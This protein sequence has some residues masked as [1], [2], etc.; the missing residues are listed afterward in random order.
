MAN[1]L[2]PWAEIEKKLPSF[3]KPQQRQ[4]RKAYYQEFWPT[5]AEQPKAAQAYY[6]NQIQPNKGELFD[7][8]YGSMGSLQGTA[9]ALAMIPTRGFGFAVEGGLNLLRRGLPGLGGLITGRKGAAARNL[10]REQKARAA[11]GIEDRRREAA[12]AL[13]D[14]AA[15]WRQQNRDILTGMD[16]E[17]ETLAMGRVAALGR[18]DLAAREAAREA[19]S[20]IGQKLL[21]AGTELMPE[22][23]RLRPTGGRAFLEPGDL[24]FPTTGGRV[25][26]QGP[27]RVPPSIMPPRGPRSVLW[28]VEV[29]ISKPSSKGLRNTPAAMSPAM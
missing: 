27:S 11:P 14:N 6:Y 13:W 17:R 24:P 22:T 9:E 26:S 8:L 3:S 16:A 21:T 10:L 4:I 29:I 18:S 20:R 2:K 7:D 28:V 15:N 5:V 1:E 25:I 12:E 19:Q 23:F